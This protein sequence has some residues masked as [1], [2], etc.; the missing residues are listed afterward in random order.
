MLVR[1]RLGT[2]TS[3]ASLLLSTRHVCIFVVAMRARMRARII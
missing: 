1:S 3:A 2:Q